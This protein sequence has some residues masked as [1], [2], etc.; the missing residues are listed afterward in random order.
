MGDL[1]LKYLLFGED[2]TASKTLKHVGDEAGHTGTRLEGMGAR[3]SNAL[4]I[5]GGAAAAAAVAGVA[6]ISA[7]IVKGVSDAAEYQQL[8]AKTAAVLASTG[9]A[10]GQSVKGIQDRAAA[11]ESMSGIDETLIINGQNVLATFTQVRDQV[12][13]G[14]DIFT[15]ATKAALDM[16]VALGTDLQGA[17]VQ[18]GKALNDPIKGITALGRAGVSFTQAQK[19][20]IKTLVQH[21]DTLGAQKIILG[22]LSKEF[23]GAAK[24]AGEGF[25]GSMERAKDAVGDAFREVGT[26]LL[27]VLTDL[28]NWFAAEGM[29]RIVA[30]AKEAWPKVK[31]AF[32]TVSAVITEK[33]IPAVKLVVEWFQE[34]VMPAAKDLGEKVLGGLKSAWDSISK[35]IEENRPQLEAIG[36]TFKTIAEWIMAN[37]V[38]LLGTVLVGVR[39]AGRHHRRGHHGDR[40]TSRRAS[41]PSQSGDL[42]VEQRSPADRSVHPERVCLS[43]TGIRVV[44][45]VSGT[46]PASGGRMRPRRCPARP[47][48]PSG[49]GRTLG[50]SPR[51]SASKSQCPSSGCRRSRTPS[52]ALAAA[53]RPSSTPN[54]RASPATPAAPTT[55]VVA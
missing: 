47:T 41:R 10:A 44:L 28:A 55:G 1:T 16:S 5:L 18:L 43:H 12:G 54:L 3:A 52:T 42:A 26:A 40:A 45:V 53:C 50:R 24:A 31:E 39:A 23:G 13:A 22:E 29:P 27:P 35:A 49:S 4:G 25:S 2:R 15:Q 46:C 32:A 6:A 30:F 34:H 7:G 20:Q 19:D 38:P 14:N 11:L 9:N 8:A 37:V 51:T 36:Q 48:K 17:N 33:V 21:G